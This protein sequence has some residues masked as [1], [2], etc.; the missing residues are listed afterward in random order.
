MKTSEEVYNRILTDSK[1]NACNFM[2][3]YYDSIKKKYIDIPVL[4]WKSIKNGGDIP[5]S[6][7]YF[8]KFKTEII[9]N[10]LDLTYNIED[11]IEK[12]E[13]LPS[14]IKIMTF[15]V[16]SDIY[17]KQITN[18]KKRKNDLINFI[19]NTD[20][21]IICLQ[22]ITDEFYKEL[23]ILKDDYKYNITDS[24]TNNIA[25]LSKINPVNCEIIDLDSKASK[26][27][28][29]LVFK[30][31]DANELTIV[32]IHLTSDTHKNSKSIRIQQIS[33]INN[34]LNLNN[35]CVILGDTNEIDAI[36]QLA[37]FNDSN[38]S[39]KATYDPEN[40]LFAKQ[41]SS[42]G[43]KCRYDRIY[44]YMLDCIEF[45]VIENNSLSDHYPV[46]GRYN[47]NNDI[48]EYKISQEI[49]TTF[50]TALCIIPKFDMQ[51]NIPTYNSN[52]M[53]HINI[54]W[55]FIPQVD[56]NKYYSLLQNI[57]IDPFVL[58]LNKIGI[59][60]H[61]KNTTVYLK[62]CEESIKKMREIYDKYSSVF[63]NKTSS[64][65]NPHLSIETINTVD[66]SEE[67]I[68]SKYNYD[69]S[70]NVD[71]LYFA[72]REKTE[73]IAIKKI[74][75]LDHER[76]YINEH[77]KNIVNF[78]QSFDCSVEICGSRFFNI[79]EEQLLNDSD[80]DLL[81]IGDVERVIFYNKL[82][83]PIGQCGLFYK[84]EII[85]NDH[86]YELKLFSSYL[87]VDIQYVNLNNKTEQYYNTSYNLFEQPNYA[88]NC[89]GEQ[90]ELFK[91]C[92]FWTKS[93]L[94]KYKIYGQMYGYLSGASIVILVTFIIT[95]HNAKSLKDYIEILKKIDFDEIISVTHNTYNRKT[96]SDDLMVIQEFT[97]P[98]E[99]TVRNITK[100]TK[101]ILVDIF[102]N[103]VL[104]IDL[105]Y[106]VIFNFESLDD[107]N[108]YYLEELNSF[109]NMVM[110]KLVIKLEKNT[111]SIIK[112]FNK[113]YYSDNNK[114]LYFK[115]RHNCN[116]NIL[117]H[118]IDKI[119][120]YAEN[121]I[122][123]KNISFCIL[124]K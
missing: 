73:Y 38:N 32:G 74:L 90:L 23:F 30:I 59:F 63:N 93:L 105:P 7:V 85:K 53:P 72:S 61:D 114:K 49:N 56:F 107:E 19:K 87:T 110:V 13:Y 88:I 12:K 62:P 48:E 33:K 14:I 40:N 54:F 103:N 109:M 116:S 52:W 47:I 121:I 112:P 26:K 29:K 117:D 91:Q 11:C 78:L 124:K 2:L 104:T 111:D 76:K 80:L 119:K 96:K 57:H 1:F 68:A 71:C 18:L 4:Q 27:A 86:I 65:F 37:I 67:E 20:S 99:N 113:W 35:P 77:I 42:K 92:L 15:N 21:D 81:C 25:I 79:K 22:E 17:D 94:K 36:D 9:W 100:S 101:K 95:K 97:Y 70:F 122:D 60:K 66:K 28:L 102:K 46:I 89:V 75:N 24:K 83:K 45:D 64:E 123:S 8:I 39:I 43:F 115:L 41:F 55:P 69:I 84:H 50:K 106:T 31:D 10:R 34:K 98:H 5:W 16:L 51:K 6:R 118:E 44:H 58:R 3:S 82:I 120:N 108:M